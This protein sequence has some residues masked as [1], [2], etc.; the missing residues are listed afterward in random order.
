MN[1]KTFQCGNKSIR[2][3]I[4]TLDGAHISQIEAD[5]WITPPR[6]GFDLSNPRHIERLQCL[7]DALR[8]LLQ[9]CW[10]LTL[11]MP[12]A[13]NMVEIGSEI[14][15]RSDD[16]SS[17][18]FMPSSFWRH[19]EEHRKAAADVYAALDGL[20]V[21]WEVE[22]LMGAVVHPNETE[23]SISEELIKEA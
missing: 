12:S 10:K 2:V 17:T 11:P 1:P 18:Y 13:D 15:F 9:D 8:Y 23:E 19:D 16:W 21:L 14:Y 22:Q 20:L 5:G 4:V 3:T 7:R 6:N